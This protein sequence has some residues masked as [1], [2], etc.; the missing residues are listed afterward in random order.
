MNTTNVENNDVN[1][2]GTTSEGLLSGRCPVEQQRRPGRH[3]TAEATR[4][5]WT[6]EINV[7][8]MECFYLRKSFSED[9]KPQR[10]YR[11]RMHRIWKE[12]GVFPTSEQRICDQARAIRKN[13]WLTDIELESIKQRVLRE[14]ISHGESDLER[15]EEVESVRNVEQQEDTQTTDQPEE[16]A[17]EGIRVERYEELSEDEKEIVNIK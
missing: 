4:L 11:Q 9:G 7:V 17:E 14:E 5:K 12:R 13:G 3:T 10:G 1:E 8:I 15:E 16:T 6:K 2:T